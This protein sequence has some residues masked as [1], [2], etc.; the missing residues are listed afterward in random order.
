MAYP[1]LAQAF[2]LGGHVRI[3]LEDGVNLRRGVLAPSNAAM[4]EKAARIVDELGGE[5][6]TVKDARA[7]L[8][9]KR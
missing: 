6:A 3:G 1:M 8:G 4:V 7:I 5:L 2:L 9:L